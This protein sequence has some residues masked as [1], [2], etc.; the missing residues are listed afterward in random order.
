MNLAFKEALA[1]RLLWVDV[2]VV[3]CIGGSK[4]QFEE[5]IQ[6]A[7][8][9]VHKLASNDVLIYRHYGPRA[10]QLF[11][12]I[13]ELANQYNLA[14][15]A[16]TESYYTNYHDGDLVLEANWLAPAPPLDLPYSAWILAVNN[17]VREL[18]DDECSYLH[19]WGR[20]MGIEEAAIHVVNSGSNAPFPI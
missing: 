7:Y 1:A 5:A 15:E 19:A 16:Y 10:P 11:L 6:G 2:V 18:E 12:D 4:E 20:G 17:R 14:H 8:D 13:P 9:A 3:D